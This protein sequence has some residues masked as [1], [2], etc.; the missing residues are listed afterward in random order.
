MNR[1]LW[2]FAAVCATLVALA[3]NPVED[4]PDQLSW[5]TFADEPAF[6]RD[7]YVWAK[8]NPPPVR[9]KKSGAPA[10]CP[11]V[12][13]K[14]ADLASDNVQWQVQTN[15]GVRVMR[16]PGGHNFWDHL[17]TT[18]EIPV[19]GTYRMWI[20]YRHRQGWNETFNVA[21]TPAADVIGPETPVETA[22][23]AFDQCFARSNGFRGRRIDPIPE[24]CD[25]PTPEGGYLWEG[26]HR[27]AYLKAGKYVLTFKGGQ[28]DQHPD[29][30]IRDI[31]FVQ[32]PLFVPTEK[33]MREKS[34]TGV[35][36]P[37]ADYLNPLFAVRPGARYE[38]MPKKILAYWKVW[39]N[40][41]YDKLERSERTDYVWGYL[42][43]YNY[44]DE[45][46]NLIGRVRE[47]RT[48]KRRDARPCE[49]HKFSGLDFPENDAWKRD[50]FQ[51]EYY[52][53]KENIT[54]G[55]KNPK[56]TEGTTS[57]DVKIRQGG[58]YWLWVQYYGWGGTTEV[59]VS[60]KGKR[61]G[62]VTAGRE[63]GGG[64]V[65]RSEAF[66]LPAGNI[67]LSLR[68][69]GD[70]KTGKAEGGASVILRVVLTQ[71]PAL[72]PFTNREC[73]Q[74]DGAKVGAE[75]LGW[76]R[77]NPFGGL[78][79]CSP[80]ATWRYNQYGPNHWDPL[81]E[82]QIC[83][84]SYATNAMIGEVRTEL[85]VVR[86]NTDEPIAFEP[87]V[88][89]SLPVKLRT[90]AS[91]VTQS[92]FWS[93]MLLLERKR[94]TVPAHQNTG[95]WLTIDCRGAKE[96][97]YPVVLSFA[98]KKITYSIAVKDTLAGTKEPC[99]FPY[100]FPYG[101]RS[102]WD[103]Y[104]DLGWNLV[105][106]TPVS[107]RVM[108]EYGIRMF[109]GQQ[110]VWEK[111]ITDKNWNEVVAH[112][113]KTF[114][115]YRKRGIEPEDFCW[116]LIDEPYYTKVPRWMQM[117]KALREA[118]PRCKIWCN[119]GFCPPEPKH[120]D[121]YFG[122]MPYTDVSCPY[123]DQFSRKPDYKPWVDRL[124]AT[125]EL[126]LLYSTLD[127]GDVEKL[128]NAPQDLINV[129]RR[130]LEEGR[131]GFA[132]FTMMAG[133]AYDDLYIGNG[134]LA[135]SVYPGAFGRTISTR[136]AEATR[137]ALQMMRKAWKR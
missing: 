37:C 108:R 34:E 79:R 60:A 81:P 86:N 29:M 82:N 69:A 135:V 33:D 116:Y 45:E 50:R 67:K 63:D 80:P 73:E 98:N 78:T 110:H 22:F 12:W 92:G 42:A 66:E 99:F 96:G 85:L 54:C 30:L 17:R 134:D 6:I 123:I 71:N 1:G 109:I 111:E 94:V 62:A 43:T 36:N 2:C 119:L 84:T 58:R 130:A 8:E 136:N 65:A 9:L 31:L 106:Y 51:R 128:P 46:A 122:M 107:K 4:E 127:I 112:L 77:Q 59:S 75:D 95:L 114:A 93:P 70:K 41:L 26:T 53:L 132:N 120:W 118:E 131:D 15:D 125:G 100:A 25:V 104:K 21:M 89:S 87:T 64:R 91:T 32:D 68:Y 19:S 5:S 61:C 3:K 57:L 76:W 56:G 7:F 49:T 35:M 101:R 48:Q 103:L 105:G 18:V 52:G 115:D 121:L 83:A 44:F 124:R 47:V 133:P 16:G 27:L 55:A 13:I 102:C 38:E 39:R 24:I 11:Y 20:A 126:K 28:Y 137:E 129:A 74:P 23:T 90:V 10:E 97:S 113:R 14:A 117:A 88:E 40:H 72:E